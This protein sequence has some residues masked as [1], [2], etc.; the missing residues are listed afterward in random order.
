MTTIENCSE[1]APFVPG[2]LSAHAVARHSRGESSTIPAVLHITPAHQ[3]SPYPV[4]SDV[5]AVVREGERDQ[6]YRVLR[7]DGEG[8]ALIADPA[9]WLEIAANRPGFLRLEGRPPSAA[10]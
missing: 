2:G 10:G 7:W 4:I 8:N 5:H 6:L 3:R 9:G 1:Q